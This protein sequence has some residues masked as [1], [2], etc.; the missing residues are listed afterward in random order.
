VKPPTPK[1]H[2]VDSELP[3]IEGEDYEAVCK[4][5]VK[6][7]RYVPLSETDYI[8]NGL[9]GVSMVKSRFI[10][11]ACQETKWELSR[12]TLVVDG[13]EPIA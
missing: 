7:V 13:T 10:C 12:R 5:M 6:R 11:S 9:K 1:P 2:F 4:K 8:P 3:L